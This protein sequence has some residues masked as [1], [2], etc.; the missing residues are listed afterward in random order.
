MIDEF[1]EGGCPSKLWNLQTKLLDECTE[2]MEL[3]RREGRDPSPLFE[4]RKKL[5]GQFHEILKNFSGAAVLMGET[6]A[7][8]PQF[9]PAEKDHYRKDFFRMVDDVP[10]ELRTL[11]FNVPNLPDEWRSELEGSL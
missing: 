7:H 5:K 11:F 9:S 1:R 2:L 6:L 4:I 3:Y 10:P 8:W